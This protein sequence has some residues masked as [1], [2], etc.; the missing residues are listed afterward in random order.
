MRFPQNTIRAMTLIDR[1]LVPSR[2]MLELNHLSTR[3]I[4]CILFCVCAQSGLRAQAGLIFVNAGKAAAITAS[5]VD[6]AGN[7]YVA[8][9][10]PGAARDYGPYSGYPQYDVFV[11]KTDPSGQPV[12]RY[13]MGGSSYDA[14]TALAVGTDG[15][16]LV[17]G[18]TM[19]NDFPELTPLTGSLERDRPSGFLFKLDN[20]GTH[21]SFSTRFGANLKGDSIPF[22]NRSEVTGLTLA[23]DGSVYLC[24]TTTLGFV[25]ITP[26][27]IP[28]PEGGN[29]GFNGSHVFA[30]KLDASLSRIVYST[31]ISGS[32]GTCYGGGTGSLCSVGYTVAETASA[33]AVDGSGNITICGLTNTHNFPVTS[34]AFQTQGPLFVARLNADATRVIWGTTVG[35]GAGYPF[36]STLIGGMALDP[37]GDVVIAGSTGFHMFPTTAGALAPAAPGPSNSALFGFVTRLNPTG[38][39]LV[40]STY[41]GG[42]QREYINSV[43]IDVKGGIWISGMTQSQDYPSAPG[44]LQLG[45]TVLVQ[46]SAK[47]NQIQNVDRLPTGAAGKLSLNGLGVP[48]LVGA[49]GSVYRGTDFETGLAVPGVYAV[50]NSAATAASQYIAPGSFVS[51]YG[52]GL[53][54]ATAAVQVPD[55]AGVYGT[56]A[57]GVQVSFD[58]TAAPI[59]YAGPSQINV[60]V[61]SRIDYGPT[62]VVRVRCASGVV[63]TFALPI[64]QAAP[65]L[66]TYQAPMIG[67]PGL[68]NYA[69]ARNEDDRPNSDSS[70]ASVGSVVTVF[71]N[72]VG[73]MNYPVADGAIQAD[74]GSSPVLPVSAWFG[75]GQYTAEVDSATTAPGFVSG[76]I[77]IKLRIPPGI[78]NPAKLKVQVG[79]VVAPVASLFVK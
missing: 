29:D 42:T 75:S 8:G 58:G 74:T 17:A 2:T 66:F 50:A 63:Q 19:S 59:L 24:G 33:I 14:P 60:I 47:L 68:A 25:P 67:L 23:K 77:Q 32:A 78:T 1:L 18:V 5:T 7:I 3:F 26:G 45:N 53:G 52:P 44:S 30:M 37:S 51:F 40:A 4:R 38:S 79:D 36:T 76:V 39:A 43:V 10:V 13:T 20:S 12:Y 56:I 46:L 27:T 16:V 70:P 22:N 55:A 11:V 73:Y 65:F 54:P 61:P 15:S 48:I 72:G 34:G 62:T 71:A 57:A 35:Q 28:L 69:V 6:A 9:T 64:L 21:L 41:L 49:D 31:Y